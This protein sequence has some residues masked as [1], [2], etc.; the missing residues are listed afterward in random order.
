M[1][2][3]GVELIQNGSM[4]ALSAVSNVCD[5]RFSMHGVV[6]C[7][8]VGTLWRPRPRPMQDCAIHVRCA[9]VAWKT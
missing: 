2:H 9:S 4:A 5:Q 8:L 3:A 6:H 1:Q 7:F